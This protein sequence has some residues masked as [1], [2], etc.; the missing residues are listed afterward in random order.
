MINFFFQCHLLIEIELHNFYSLDV[1]CLM[2]RVTGLK[3]KHSFK[4]ILYNSFY[5]FNHILVT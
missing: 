1:S 5:F 4:K 3:S 2:T